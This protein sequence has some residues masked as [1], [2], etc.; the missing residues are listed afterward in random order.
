MNYL[1]IILIIPLL[2]G[3]Y[4]GL[5]KG[6]VREVSTL[7]ALFLGIYGAVNFAKDLEPLFSSFNIDKAFVPL[8]SFAVA[9]LGIVVL[10]NIIGRIFDRLTK[11]VA[12]GPFTKLLGAVFGL[13]KYLVI[14]SAILY[15]FNPIERELKIIEKQDKTDSLLYNPIS[16]IFPHLLPDEKER[17]TFIRDAKKA[18]NKT[19]QSII[20]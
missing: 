7:L 10:V 5:K 18:W 14:M 2:W 16:S 19:E 20:E 6:I 17:K 15:F 8:I 1:D 9:F 4:H 12:L 13:A 11:M 3:G